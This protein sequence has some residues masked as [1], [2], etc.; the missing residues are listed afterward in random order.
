MRAVHAV[1]TRLAEA[2]ESRQSQAVTHRRAA[3]TRSNAALR[4]GS[5]A[6]LAAACAAFVAA[7]SAGGDGVARN[8]GRTGGSGGQAANGT[9]A[10]GSDGGGSGGTAGTSAGGTLGIDA[11]P[12]DAALDPDSACVAESA[13]AELIARPI[14]VILLIDTSSTMQPAVDQVEANINQNFAGI[15][16]SSGLDF[17]VIVVAQHSAGTDGI[18][19]SS[20]LSGTTCSP[21]P[22][23]PVN[24]TT[25]FHYDPGRHLGSS[26]SLSEALTGYLTPDVHGLA[27]M[28]FSQWVRD[29]SFKIFLAIN[30][31]TSEDGSIDETQFDQ[32]LLALVPARFGTATAREYV[33]HSIVGLNENS[34]PTK[35]WGP[36]DPL[37]TGTCTGYAGGVAAG[38]KYQRLSLLTGGLRLPLCQFQAFDEVF[39]VIATAVI[40]KAEVECSYEMPA[41]PPGET[42]DTSTIVVK[43]TSGAGSPV[44]F[45]QAASPSACAPSKFFVDG[46]GVHLCPDTCATVQ[47]DPQA[48][49]DLLFGCPPPPPT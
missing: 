3:A 20:P 38:L 45:S 22:A 34:P 47:A 44:T 28:G 7:C 18:C 16:G 21:V 43:Y 23:T 8:D 35:P 14:D 11:G 36:A 25:F 27:P 17:R 12:D 9:G 31:A 6:G 4:R 13:T 10:G 41:A 37:Q 26:T 30:D 33:F 15:L 46:A 42:I 2:L 1:A 48:Q 40:E 32:Q 19:V 29:G 24:T 49:I 5:R 39:K